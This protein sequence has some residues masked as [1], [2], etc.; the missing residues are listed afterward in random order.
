MTYFDSIHVQA[1]KHAKRIF[2]LAGKYLSAHSEEA[3]KELETLYTQTS[4]YHE[5][6]CDA[7]EGVMAVHAHILALWNVNEHFN[8]N[9]AFAYSHLAE[10]CYQ[11]FLISEMPASEQQTFRMYLRNVWLLCAYVDYCNDNFYSSQEWLQKLHADQASAADIAL[12]ASVL[13]RLTMEE[14]VDGFKNAFLLFQEM[15]RRFTKTPLHAFEEDILRTAYG[16][17]E[18]YYTHGVYNEQY[19]IP[20]NPGLAVQI[21]SRAYPLFTDPQQKEWMQVNINDAKEKC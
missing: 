18:L 21:L 10:E 19:P 1:E 17:Y 12:T 11:K 14:G 20:Y 8:L 6:K 16:F 13:F 4:D 3:A 15:D 2:E 9:L 7:Y 5:K